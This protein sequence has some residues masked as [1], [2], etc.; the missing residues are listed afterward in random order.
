MKQN[1]AEAKRSRTTWNLCRMNSSVPTAW[2]NLLLKDTMPMLIRWSD[3][4][5]IRHSASS[6]DEHSVFYHSSRNASSTLKQLCFLSAPHFSILTIPYS[7]AQFWRCRTLQQ[8]WVPTVLQCCTVTH[9][10]F[11]TY[12]AL[13]KIQHTFCQRKERNAALG[14]LHGP[15]SRN[16]YRRFNYI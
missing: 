7:Q 8:C 3:S 4:S 2:G 6:T 13:L 10:N 14:H 12:F 11:L 1:K 16:A 5:P 15:Q 9:T